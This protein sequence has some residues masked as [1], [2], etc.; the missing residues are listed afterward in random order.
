MR[1]AK[2]GA[3]LGD[4]HSAIELADLFCRSSRRRVDT[5]FRHLGSNDDDRA[6]KLARALLDKRFAWLES[7]TAGVEQTPPAG[8]E[9]GA[10]AAGD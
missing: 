4:E 3:T 7:G 1:D 2:Q 8:A 6:Y 10:A 9:R 5:L